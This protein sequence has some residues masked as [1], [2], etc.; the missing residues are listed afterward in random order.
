MLS[1]RFGKMN[2]TISAERRWTAVREAYVSDRQQTYGQRMESIHSLTFSSSLKD[3]KGNEDREDE[4]SDI[5]LVHQTNKNIINLIEVWHKFKRFE[6]HNDTL[7]YQSSASNE[8]KCKSDKFSLFDSSIADA[9]EET[10]LLKKSLACVTMPRGELAAKKG[11]D[12]SDDWRTIII[13]LAGKEFR[14]KLKN[15][16]K[17]PMSRLGII[18]NAKSKDTVERLCDGFI[19]GSTPT[20]YFDRNPQNFRMILDVYIRNEMHVC[21]QSCALVVQEDFDYWG[22]DDVFLQPCCALKYFPLTDRAKTEKDEDK[23][24]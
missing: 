5:I 7:K 6:N 2:N 18:A 4:T 14:T 1:P 12:T 24:E 16:K 23:N 20:I 3:E 21:E 15:L 11:K 22:L 9:N 8:Q 10:I 19:P 13:S 17:Y